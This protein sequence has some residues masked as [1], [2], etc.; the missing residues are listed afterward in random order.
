MEEVTTLFDS[1]EAENEYMKE[2]Q[3]KEKQ[4]QIEGMAK[5]ICGNNR[6][7]KNCVHNSAIR[8]C[9]CIFYAKRLYEQS[10]RKQSEVAREI[11]EEIEKLTFVSGFGGDVPNLVIMTAKGFAELKKKYTEEQTND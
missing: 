10:Y 2:R 1:D 11:F 3:E 6:D 7:C 8:E 4:K 5:V 9:G